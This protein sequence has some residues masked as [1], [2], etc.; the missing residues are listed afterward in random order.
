MNYIKDAW[1]AGDQDDK[2]ST[3]AM[4]Y[5]RTVATKLRTTITQ[6]EFTETCNEMRGYLTELQG[7]GD[8]EI[9]EA[10]HAAFLID[11]V[12]LIDENGVQAQFVGN[13][14]AGANMSWSGFSEGCS[15]LREYDV[16]LSAPGEAGSGDAGSGASGEVTW[17]VTHIPIGTSW[18]LIPASFDPHPPRTSPLI[19]PLPTLTSYR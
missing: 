18:M 9:S 2:H 16:S 8:R 7:S 13:Y 14:S 1:N 10:Q 6:D 5:V 11:M 4:G 15:G 19:P 3:A 12:K 17:N